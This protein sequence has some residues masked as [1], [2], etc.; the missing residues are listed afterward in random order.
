LVIVV[1]LFV[2][3]GVFRISLKVWVDGSDVVD[4]E[5]AVCL[6]IVLGRIVLGFVHGH[7]VMFV[8]AWVALDAAHRTFWTNAIVHILTAD[9]AI[10]RI[11]IRRP[12]AMC[13]IIPS[14]VRHLSDLVLL[15]EVIV[16]P[17]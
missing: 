15:P 13:W 8:T 4:G 5:T 12:G 1:I 16:C 6:L 7:A 14:E 2:V 3:F 9:L 11:V 17:V 10:L